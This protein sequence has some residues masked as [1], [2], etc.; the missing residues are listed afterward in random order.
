MDNPEILATYGTQNKD[1]EKQNKETFNENMN[2]ADEDKNLFLTSM[3][4]MHF[5]LRKAHPNCF[6]I[7]AICSL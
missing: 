3:S 4:I 7:S 1:E 2:F 5:V 6:D